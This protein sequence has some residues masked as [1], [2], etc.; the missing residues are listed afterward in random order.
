MTKF[1]KNHDL[2]PSNVS[3]QDMEQIKVTTSADAKLSEMSDRRLLNV[4]LRG[5]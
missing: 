3:N 1:H 5:K 2:Q 4:H